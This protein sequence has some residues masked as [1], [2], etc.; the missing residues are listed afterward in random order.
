MS[1]TFLSLQ[2]PYQFGN[3]K[4][5]S[6]KIKTWKKGWLGL[7]LVILVVTEPNDLTSV[8]LTEEALYLSQVSVQPIKQPIESL[9][10]W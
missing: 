10:T 3:K 9:H 8:W 2:R 6:N 1:D 5:A 7:E 4:I